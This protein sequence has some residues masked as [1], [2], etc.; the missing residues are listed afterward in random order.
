MAFCLIVDGSLGSVETSQQSGSEGLGT[1]GWFLE[2]D[3]RKERR[4]E[5]YNRELSYVCDLSLRLNGS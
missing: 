2:K 3:R 1:K 4:E 5:L